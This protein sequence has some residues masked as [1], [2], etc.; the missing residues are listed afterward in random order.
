M[1]KTGSLLFFICFSSLVFSQT[2]LNGSVIDDA[3]IP[4]PYATITLSFNDRILAYTTTNEDGTYLLEFDKKGTFKLSFSSLGYATKTHELI[5]T[6]DTKELVY[7]ATLK[8]QAV[9]LNEVVVQERLAVKQKKDTIVFRVDKFANGTEQTV[10]DLLKKLPGIT[11]DNT[12]T[13]KVGNQ[14]IEKL[15]IDGD[16]FFEKGYKVLSK[17]MPAYPIDEV[18]LL[19]NYSNN[20]LLKDIENSNNVALN[21]KLKQEAKRLWFGNLDIAYGLVTGNKYR[22]KSN[23][24]NFGKNNKYYFLANLNNVGV[25]DTGD[26]D[27]IINPYRANQPGSIGDDQKVSSPIGLTAFIPNFKKSRTNFNNAELISLNAI[28]NPTEKLKLRTLGFFNWDENSFFR[29]TINQVGVNGTNFTNTEEY[30]LNNTKKIAFGKV[31]LTYNISNTKMLEV[32]T[33]FNKGAFND[34]SNLLFNERPTIER[35]N[36]DNEL[37]DQKISF[38]NKFKEKKVFLATGRLINEKSPQS[39]TINNFFYNTLFTES[40][41]VDEVAQQVNSQMQFAGLNLHLISRNKNNDLLELQLG[42]EYRRDRLISQ[43]Q[44]LE[45]DILPRAPDGYQNNTIYAVNNIYTKFKYEYSFGD[46]ALISKLDFHKFFNT[47]YINENKN[48]QNPFFINPSLGFDWK[49]NGKNKLVSSY[50]YTTTNAKVLDVYNDFILAGFRSFGK[51]TGS[52]NQLDASSLFINYELGNWSDNFFANAFIVYNKNHDF[53]STNTLINQDYTQSN[54]ILIKDRQFLSANTT[55]DNYLKFLSSNLKLELGY[56]I[57][58][59][60]NS[61]NNLGLRMV[62]SKSYNYGLQLRSGFSGFFNYHMG[63]K[64]TTSEITTGITNSFT[65]NVS[66]LNV[67]L[68]F[69]E[70]L[71]LE[72]QSERYVFGNLDV[73]N[74]YDFLDF[75][76]R[77]AINKNKITLGLNGRNMF[78]TQKFR[79]FSISDIG[80]ST[81]EYRLLP[82]FVLLKLE[83][84]F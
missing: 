55:M 9:S 50:S 13:I 44:L 19:K 67:T 36:S 11:V 72:L 79:N 23:L 6:S 60:K 1:I 84:R 56:T 46:F 4:L 45:D 14:E 12:G 24:M 70:K 18:E 71:N 34:N 29:N 37:F 48:S 22:S 39:Y 5:I 66:F 81:T 10:E 77:Y 54:K 31:D 28:F 17:N 62:T 57:S 15:M 26:L 58:E 2:T 73:D 40:D 63:T 43:F 32:T 75:D 25:Y 16:D 8:E 49:I 64:W 82:R 38:T 51:G 3:N 21:I 80:T 53:F 61:I 20:R 74:S 42:N 68:T 65:D 78:N 33:K 47:L 7:N 76:L 69:N 52:F 83:Y 59:Y 30:T 27:R 35:L 41:N